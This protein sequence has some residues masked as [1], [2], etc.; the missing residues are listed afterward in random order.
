MGKKKLLWS[1]FLLLVLG[2]C[3]KTTQQ[4]V[5]N[6]KQTVVRF[7]SVVE[8]NDITRTVGSSWSANDLIGVFMK[9][10]GEVLGGATIVGGGDNISYITKAGDG[11][12]QSNG[13]SLEYPSDGSAVD[14]IAYYPFQ[15]TLD[16]Y[17]YKVDVT[18]QSKPEKID[19]LY[20]D[21]LKNR[22]QTSVTG[23]LQFYHQLSQLILNLS[24]S[25]NTDLSN[26]TVSI[27]GVKTKANFNLVDGSLAVDE[28]SEAV[29]NMRRVGNA[30]EAILLPINTVDG[31]KLTLTLN[32]KAKEVTLPS[33]ISS[34]EKAAKY[35][36]SVNIKN[37][38]S[39]VDPEEAKYAK[40]RETP[41]ITKSMLE[42][43][44][45]H[46]INH[47]MPNDKKVRNYSLL[48]DSDLKM[49]YWV[50]YPLC[51]YYTTGTG[52]RTDDWGFDPEISSDLQFNFGK[53][54]SSNLAESSKYDRGHQLPSADRLRDNAV[55]ETTFYSTNIT[56]QINRMNQQIWQRLEDQVR[57]WISG[58]DTVFVV[59]GAMVDKDN[60]EYTTAKSGGGNIAVPKYY[61]KALARK[62]SSTGVFYTIAFK[63]DNTTSVAGDNYMEHAVS[64]D[65]LEKMT[66]FTFFPTVSAD[67]KATLDKSKWQ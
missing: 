49:A 6:E 8:G 32:G 54:S 15:S 18:D 27:S 52:D 33:S 45:I 12:F 63:I 21:N 61:F 40:W 24:S 10:S 64:V 44:N 28:K 57:K 5:D 4:V 46:Y 36:F 14:F 26:L 17:I 19:L 34:L 65:A 58:V 59:T 30:A 37:G 43:N 31:I 23:N 2:A 29:V 3:D 16:N 66:G 56:P 60:V 48:Y 53:K 38:G 50:A 42:K 20:A 11:N 55:N 67:I 7:T 47:Y 62:L 39:Q 13:I 51:S 41:V 25:D 35:I 1:A 22:T 9:Q